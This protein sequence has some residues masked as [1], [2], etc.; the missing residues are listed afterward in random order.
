MVDLHAITVRQNPADL[1]RRTLE[2]Y[3]ILMACGLDPDQSLMF[4]Q[5]HVQSHSELAWVLSTFT[6]FGELSRMTQFKDKSQKYSENINAGLFTYPVLMAAD[7]LLYNTDL[8]PVGVDQKQHLEL[9]RDIAIRFN[10]LYSPTFKV[11]DAYI[12]QVGAKISSLAD[13]LKKMSKSDENENAYISLLDPY[14]AIIR[15]F[16]RA[17]TDSGD[18]IKFGAD[19]PGISNL[20]GIY[21]AVTGENNERIESEFS[22]KGYG[23]FKTAV[24]ETVADLLKPVQENFYRLMEDKEYLAQKYAKGANDALK[25]SKRMTDKVYRKVGFVKAGV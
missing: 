18:E 11:P 1:R 9:T 6:Q 17:V 25:L 23:Y 21:S 7:I 15:K 2:T 22:G 5:S 8:V 24:G 13:P 4:I 20:M 14:D 3:A 10:N 12:P 16:K 19:K